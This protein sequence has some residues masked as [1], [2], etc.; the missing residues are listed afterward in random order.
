MVWR[1]LADLLV[2][3]HLCFVLFV[4]LGGLL[5]LRWRRAV[6]PWERR[7]PAGSCA[8]N[9]LSTACGTRISP[10][11]SRRRS[12]RP[13]AHSATSG[14]LLRTTGPSGIVQVAFELVGLF[15]ERRETVLAQ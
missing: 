3:F 4:V 7:R 5:A 13:I 11:R 12:S 1:L 9:S 8:K 14:V 10:K 6:C 15:A 2:A